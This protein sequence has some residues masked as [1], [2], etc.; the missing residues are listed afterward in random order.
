AVSVIA[1]SFMDSM[2]TRYSCS[3]PCSENTCGPC[4]PAITTASTSPVR[5]ARSVSSASARRARS[6]LRLLGSRFTVHGYL[7]QALLVF[8][9]VVDESANRGTRAPRLFVDILEFSRGN[10]LLVQGDNR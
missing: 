5:M 7:L 10:V 8:L 6:L 2:S 4:L 1:P 3:A 9:E